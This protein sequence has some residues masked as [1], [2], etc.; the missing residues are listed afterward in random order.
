MY[1][2]LHALI[3]GWSQRYYSSTKEDDGTGNDG[4]GTFVGERQ[5]G[6][7]YAGGKRA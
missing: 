1:K 3:A 4:Y 6:A 7:R 5:P 2:Y